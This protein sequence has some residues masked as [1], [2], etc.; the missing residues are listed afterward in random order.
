V[1]IT[2]NLA[3]T[4]SVALLA[5]L[6]VSGYGFWQ[7]RQ[8]QERFDYVEVDTIPAIVDLAEATAQMSELRA[9]TLSRVLSASELQRRDRDQRIAEAHRRLDA[10]LE[11]YVT[12]HTLDDTDSKMVEV[13]KANIAAYRA[14]QAQFLA[15]TST[16]ENAEAI[17]AALL[18]LTPA[19]ALVVNALKD[20]TDYNIEQARALGARGEAAARFSLWTLGATTLIA[21]VLTTILATC[22]Y[23]II[24]RGLANIQLTLTEVSQSLDLTQRARVERTDEIGLTAHAFNHFIERIGTVLWTVRR[25]SDSVSVAARQ[26]AAGNTDLSSRTE[27]QAASLEETA[28]SMEEL[29]SA[30]QHTAD[31]ARQASVLT[32]S[33]SAL[34]R[35]GHEVVSRV[36]DTMHEIDRS[37]DKISEITSL[38]E[39]IAFQTNI[40]AL[41]AAVEAA[42]AGEQGRGF[43]VV[44][45]E[46][47]N[48]AQ[49]SASAAKEIKD[50]IAA[51]VQAIHD[52][53]SLA[54]QA[55]ET[56]SEVTVAVGHVAGVITEI[57]AASEQQSQGIKQISNAITQM[58][59]V[60]QQ[61]AALVEEAAAAAKSL[62][63]QGRQLD[64]AVRA[65]HFKDVV[66]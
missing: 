3:L 43:A 12:D 9:S 24:Q 22:L 63:D 20:Q 45:A 27:Q 1:T 31:S 33:A 28:A 41:N 53:S 18:P 64:L 19:T 4:L 60:T 35:K 21:F 58:D 59:Q 30:V 29:T 7:L 39:G 16:G 14:T 6:F 54:N 10:I 57:A 51:S 38:I 47:R 61:N 5:L 42:R 36:V 66:A 8:F 11:R 44:A 13:D 52:G 26:I 37:S 48:L 65:F 56:I 50:L 49:R 32:G 23:R 40:L 55:G 15:A 17:G 62:E 34:A 2:R 25:S 46:V